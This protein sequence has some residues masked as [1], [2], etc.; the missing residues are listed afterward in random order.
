MNIGEAA[1]VNVVLSALI[2]QKQTLDLLGF[3]V[4]GTLIEHSVMLADR[5]HKVLMAGL[6]G[7]QVKRAMEGREDLG[8][9]LDQAFG[10]ACSGNE[11]E[12]RRP[13]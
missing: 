6:T 9:V 3:R 10:R 8:Q 11:T 4:P 2:G 7:E 12:G 1:A 13:A 5:A